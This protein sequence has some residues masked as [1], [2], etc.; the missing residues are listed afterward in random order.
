MQSSFL[1]R[2]PGGLIHAVN[3]KTMRLVSKR[4]FKTRRT[5]DALLVMTGVSGKWILALSRCLLNFRLALAVVYDAIGLNCVFIPFLPLNP[6][7]MQH[8]LEFLA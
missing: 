3:S 4:R 1:R 6:L 8:Y 2:P 7:I 5:N